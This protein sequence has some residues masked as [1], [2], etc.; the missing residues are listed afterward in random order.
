[1]LP[2]MFL[3]NEPTV[4]LLALLAAVLGVVAAIL[5]IVLVFRRPPDPYAWAAWSKGDLTRSQYMQHL[6]RVLRALRAINKVIVTERNRQNLLDSACQVLMDTRGYKMAWIGLVEQGTRR[7]RPVSQAG[8]ENGY[9]D[10]IEVTWDDSATGR[11]PTGSAIKTGE[12]RVMRDIETAPEFEPWREQALE[13]G[14]RSS[15]AFPL[16]YEGRVLGAL[17]VYSEFPNA[18]DIQEAGMLQEVAD[19]L[20]FALE[21]LR[22]EQELIQKEMHLEGLRPGHLAFKHA[23]V[24][25]I[26]A[27]AGG[28]VTG[29]N[30]RM[31]ELLPDDRGRE[32]IIGQMKL[33]DLDFFAHPSLREHLQEALEGGRPARFAIEPDLISGLNGQVTCRTAPILDEK[34]NPA[35]LVCMIAASELAPSAQRDQ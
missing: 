32:E 15:A 27:D 16:R 3:P 17:N 2:L 20:A 14:Y 30:V 5:A 34:G 21:S 28:L 29:L 22:L 35:G 24:A 12:P 13:R 33:E 7:V 18:F 19:H 9:L 25:L 31:A 1:M 10:E 11:G 6:T 26:A 8:F 4:W 23:P